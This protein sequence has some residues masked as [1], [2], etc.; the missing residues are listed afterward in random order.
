MIALRDRRLHIHTT[1]QPRLLP[2]FLTSF[3]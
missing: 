1:E 3:H 2:Q